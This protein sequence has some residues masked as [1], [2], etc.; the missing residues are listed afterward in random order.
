MT[1]ISDLEFH[2]LLA[3][4][5]SKIIAKEFNIHQEPAFALFKKSAVYKSLMNSTDEYDRIMPID[6]FDLWKNERLT[7]F[8]VSSDDIKYDYLKTK[9]C[10]CI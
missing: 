6:L 1:E 9:K 7:G 5:T 3:N 2:Q 10:M 4:E 8:S